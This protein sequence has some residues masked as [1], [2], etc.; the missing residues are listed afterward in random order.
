MSIPEERRNDVGGKIFSG[1]VVG[2]FI[3]GFSF[4]IHVVWNTSDN[5]GR[6]AAENGLK[7]ARLMHIED[8][9]KEI[10]EDIKEISKII[11]AK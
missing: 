4:F 8:D 10:K 3:I 11:H 7:I 5:A 9:I 6:K 2:S 1:I